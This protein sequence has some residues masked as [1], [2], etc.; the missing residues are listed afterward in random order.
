MKRELQSLLDNSRFLR[1]Y[2]F[3][4]VSVKKENKM[5]TVL[6]EGE[7][8]TVG[9]LKALKKLNYQNC[10][11]LEYEESEQNPLADVELCLAAVR[12]AVKKV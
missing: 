3:R 7:L 11:A 5:F 10:V 4:V 6:G 9:V 8:D 2:A 12:A 1:P